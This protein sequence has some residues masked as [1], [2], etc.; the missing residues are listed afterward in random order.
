MAIEFYCS[1]CNTLLSVPDG[2]EGR[3]SQCPSCGALADI[4]APTSGG[5]AP[6]VNPYAAPEGGFDGP[7]REV[8]SAGPTLHAKIDVGDVVSKSWAI[9]KD[10]LGI[11]VGLIVVYWV[12]TVA[13]EFML[14]MLAVGVGGRDP[15]MIQAISQILQIASS[16][17]DTWLGAGVSMAMLEIARGRDTEISRLFS[18]GRYLLRLIG[19]QVL[20]GL[21][22]LGI[23]A[24]LAGIPA[25][26]GY[27]VAGKH[28]AMNIGAV[29]IV[30]SMVPLIYLGFA[31]FATQLLIIDRDMG[32]IDSIKQSWQVTQ[33]NKLSLFLLGLVSVG[34]I[35]LGVL[36]L[37]VGII[38][39]IPLVVIIYTVA[40]LAMTG[41]PI[42]SPQAV[43]EGA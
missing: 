14:G 18:G 2:S 4:P 36:A 40:Y 7:Q 42:A 21:V 12:I 28:A 1:Q 26:F 6:A 23:M 8:V 20:L 22:A 5:N 19:L 35:I 38:F 31:M 11:A 9:F 37:V 16:V 33:G 32:I 43:Q 24:V 10:R 13:L 41:Q 17:V 15:D 25:L 27:V 30:I 29:G 39:A 3:Q 34:I